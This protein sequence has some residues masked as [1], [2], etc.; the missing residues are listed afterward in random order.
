MALDFGKGN[1]VRDET[2]GRR[3]HPVLWSSDLWFWDTFL[4]H[5]MAIRLGPVE[6]FQTLDPN[7]NSFIDMVF[8][9]DNMKL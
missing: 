4:N 5:F 7:L 6:N 3:G 1:C 8:N 2:F 9:R